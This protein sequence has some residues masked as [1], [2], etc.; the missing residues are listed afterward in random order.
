[1][2]EQCN[3]QKTCK[4]ISYDLALQ[5]EY[6]EGQIPRKMAEDILNKNIIQLYLNYEDKA[7]QGLK[8]PY[9]TK[10]DG[11]QRMAPLLAKLN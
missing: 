7:Q 8:S 2:T 4:S 9:F 1:M 6:K 10:T 11:N 5:E 3:D